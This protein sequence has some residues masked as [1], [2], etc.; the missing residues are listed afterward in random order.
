MIDLHLHT[1]ASD[2]RST[3]EE[4]V[5]AA[6]AAGCRTISVTDHDTTAAVAAV[7]RAAHGAGLGFVPGIEMTAVDRGRDI[8]ILGYYI[9]ADDPSL[10][11]FLAQQ[12]ALRRERV[13]AIAARLEAVGAPIALDD[14]VTAGLESGRAIG[15]PAVAAAL[16]A[17]GHARD[18]QDAFDRFLAEGRPGHVPR[19]GAPPAEIVDRIRRAGGLASLA[20]PAK[21]RRDDLIAPLVEAGMA[22]IEVFHTDHSA[23]ETARYAEMAAR[24]GVLV[25]GGSDFH[26]PGGGRQSGLGTV[27]LPS[28][29]FE[30]LAAYAA[31]PRRA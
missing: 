27:G 6:H 23:S 21:N 8:H 16:I 24:F 20:H 10:N 3:P 9:D 18:V 2:G 29:D 7:R 19:E 28:G 15:R 14:I 5:A 25:T 31:R 17:A 12:R 26:G 11:A 22:A 4:L 1:T 13:S 30:A